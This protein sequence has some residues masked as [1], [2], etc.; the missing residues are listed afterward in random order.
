MVK[1]LFI[2]FALDQTN[3]KEVFLKAFCQTAKDMQK[4]TYP[5]VRKFYAAAW[6]LDQIYYTYGTNTANQP[7]WGEYT[8]LMGQNVEAAL[9]D[10]TMPARE[11]Y[12]IANKALYWVSGDTNQLST[13]L[14]LR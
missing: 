3:S 11:A 13:S 5:P 8:P 9:N 4:S 14:P 6:A 1:Y 7:I 10:K 12:E 2:R